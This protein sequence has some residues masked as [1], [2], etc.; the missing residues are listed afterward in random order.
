MTYLTDL[1]Q[2]RLFLL[3]F[4]SFAAPLLIICLS[5]CRARAR[6]KAC[7]SISFFFVREDGA[8]GEKS[9]FLYRLVINTNTTA[10]GRENEKR[11]Q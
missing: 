3:F 10:T 8:E 6:I 11:K 7:I 5:L 2:E 4:L 9:L 1:H